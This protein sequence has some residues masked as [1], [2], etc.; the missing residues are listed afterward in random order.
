MS[1]ISPANTGR[2]GW[3]QAW[4]YLGLKDSKPELLSF[5]GLLGTPR[6]LVLVVQGVK[7]LSPDVCQPWSLVGAEQAPL[8]IGLHSL[9]EQ[10]VDPQGVEQV[11]CTSLQGATLMSASY[12]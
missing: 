9:H 8:C 4:P 6:L 10:V 11:S 2:P 3:G 12:G 5:D 7:L 1:A